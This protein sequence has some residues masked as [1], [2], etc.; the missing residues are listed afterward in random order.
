[1]ERKTIMIDGI[2][3]SYDDEI[4][5]LTWETNVPITLED[6][7]QTL[8]LAKRL[9]DNIGLKLYL[10]FG[11]LLGAVREQSIIKGDADVDTYVTEE[12]KLVSAIPYLH[13]NGLRLCRVVKG[14]MYSFR[15]NERSY[16]DI[17]ILRPLR[18]SIWSFY[19]LALNSNITPKKFFKE[20]QQIYFLGM[21]FSCPAEPEN[22][23]EFWYG[24]DWRI[25][26]SK[27]GHYEVKTAEIWH[28]FIARLKA[29]IKMAI[30]W[31]YWKH[32]V[33]G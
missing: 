33:K 30:G 11:T 4:M 17:Y 14:S 3:F 22:L 26:Q 15:A 10:A 1:M 5:D 7:K 25:P 32:W 31:K 16:I 12:E 23:L 29:A 21:Q 6:G 24:K 13:Q 9:L 28:S 2:P 18:F 27:K 8:E 20:T 19:C